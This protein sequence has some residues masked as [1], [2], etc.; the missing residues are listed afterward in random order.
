MRRITCFAHLALF[1]AGAFLA[2]CQAPQREISSAPQVLAEFTFPRDAKLILLPVTFQGQE[3]TFCLDTGS[4][5]VVF[6]VSLKDKL[7]KRVLWPKKGRAAHGE[8]I[9]VEYFRA[10]QAQ[11]GPLS[12][13]GSVLVAVTDLK[14]LSPH[15]TEKAQGIIGMDFLKKYVVQIDFDEARVSFLKAETDVDLLSFL[16]PKKNEHPE[17][18]EPVRIQYEFFCELPHVKGRIHDG[19]SV[20]FMVDTGWS[21]ALCLL[22]S[23]IFKKVRRETELEL[24]ARRTTVA[25]Q[26]SSKIKAAIVEALSVG[27]YKHQDVIFRQGNDSILGLPFLS[28]H[29]VTFD[30]PNRRLYL[31]KG[32]RFDKPSDFSF[33]PY[34]LG[35]HLRRQRGNI[36]VC[37][38]DPNGPAHARGIRQDDIVLTV[39]DQDV[40]SYSMAK[41]YALISQAETEDFVIAMKRGDE[42]KDF[43]FALA[44]N[45]DK[46]VKTDGTD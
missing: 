1:F 23:R 41:L 21:D 13:K 8:P 35:F 27:S 24:L 39:N 44:T 17:W 20:S 4:T 32:R 40:T 11:L 6:D 7:G 14:Q 31:K 43:S 26:T 25:G 10:P 36:F 19:I 37:S 42:I 33:E 46:R 18:G 3:H 12:L 16:R 38:V 30:F 29:L 28:R 45:P 5:D 2:G 34:D 15:L 22:D 9:K